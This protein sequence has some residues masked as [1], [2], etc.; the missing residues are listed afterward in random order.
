ML[1]YSLPSNFEARDKLS[2]PDV[3]RIKIVEENDTQKDEIHNSNA[4]AMFAKRNKN[5]AYDNKTCERKDNS[6]TKNHKT[7]KPRCSKCNKLGHRTAECRSKT[8]KSQ[9]IK[10]AEKKVSLHVDV[11]LLSTQ[12]NYTETGA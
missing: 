4:K 10:D 8:N 1:L 12:P 6:Q 7:N 11:A 2:T 5:R 9:P 3:L